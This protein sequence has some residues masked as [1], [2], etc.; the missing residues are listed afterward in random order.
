MSEGTANC[1]DIPIGII[2]P[3]L[4]VFLKFR[5]RLEFCICLLFIFLGYLPG[6][7]YAI[8]VLAATS[9]LEISLG[10]MLFFTGGW[11]RGSVNRKKCVGQHK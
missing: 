2:L 1:V 11:E 5:C 9:T 6:I 8:T 4:V 10:A 3:P 7:I